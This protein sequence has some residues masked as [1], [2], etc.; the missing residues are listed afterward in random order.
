MDKICPTNHPAKNHSANCTDWSEGWTYLMSLCRP[1]LESLLGYRRYL[2]SFE[3]KQ[4][5]K[6]VY[7][8]TQTINIML[9]SCSAASDSLG[10]LMI[11]ISVSWSWAT[12]SIGVGEERDGR[13]RAPLQSHCLYTFPSELTSANDKSEL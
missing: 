9:R 11:G 7:R 8:W 3:L 13:L 10:V 4:G 1:I 5:H 2:P 6:S 12:L